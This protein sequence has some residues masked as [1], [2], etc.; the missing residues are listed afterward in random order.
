[1]KRLFTYV[2]K[3]MH[4][5]ANYNLSKKSNQKYFMDKVGFSPQPTVAS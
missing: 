5:F 3:T 2:N 4:F 1:M